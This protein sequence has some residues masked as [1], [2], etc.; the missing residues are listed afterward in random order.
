MKFFKVDGIIENLSGYIEARMELLK[1]EIKDD[2]AKGLS[3]AVVFVVLLMAF[4]L[5]VFF[6]SMALAYKL[7]EYVTTFGGFAIV[8]G[9][10]LLIGVVLILNR[11][12]I[13]TRI[14]KQVI[15]FTRK[16]KE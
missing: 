10:Y 12:K 1:L 16:K 6:I 3:K 15:E 14:Q 5:F 11:E 4:G 2:V 13:S 8:A 9:F 7:G